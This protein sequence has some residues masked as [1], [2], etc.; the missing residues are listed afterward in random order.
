MF[1]NP[2]AKYLTKI[3]AQGLIPAFLMFYGTYLA[4]EFKFG[5]EAIEWG[6]NP[7]NIELIDKKAFEE[8]KAISSSFEDVRPKEDT[9]F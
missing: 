7:K 6:M 4:D 9:A 2:D 3:P 1:D 8:L 5:E